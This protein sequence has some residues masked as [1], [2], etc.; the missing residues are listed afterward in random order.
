MDFEFTEEQRMFRNT[1]RR[2]AEE[3]ITPLVDNAEETETL[4]IQLF[5]LMGKLGYLCVRYPPEYGGLGIGK[6]GEC[7]AVEELG[8]ISSGI[9]GAI[10]VQSGLATSSIYAHGTEEQKQKY[11]I[12]AIKGE[13]I[14]AFA[15]TEPNAGSDISS[16][17]TI[18][19]KDGNNYIINGSKIFITNAPVADFIL[20]AAYTDRGKGPRGGIS[21]LIVEKDTPGFSCRKMHKSTT[22]SAEAGELTYE[23]L[24]VS[25][26]NLVGEEGKGLSYLKETLA[27]GRLCISAR[28]LGTATAAYEASLRYSR[29]RQQFGQPIGKFQSIA[30]KLARMAMDIEAARWLVYHAAWL[31]DEGRKCMKE[32]SMAKLFSTEMVERVAHEA[33][34]IHGGYG[35][36]A[37]SPIQRHFRDARV[38]TIAEGTS[39]I[40]QLV[41]SRE[42]G[43]L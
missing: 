22:L 38:G 36:I 37:N 8:R 9:C 17:E 14:T 5:P 26:N 1:I 10:V 3:R 7:I 35:F 29:E 12:P 28:S 34:Q 4:P 21:L 24:V 19:R 40:H 13:I 41:I 31:Y 6:V 2:F 32:A 16:I 30:F 25:E 23:N 39:E 20:T 42:I 33:V 43:L 11:L 15:L 27:G 18:A